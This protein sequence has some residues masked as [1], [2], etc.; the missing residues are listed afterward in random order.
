[1][2]PKKPVSTKHK[3]GWTA[4]GRSATSKPPPQLDLWGVGILAI[5]MDCL[6]APDAFKG[7][8]QL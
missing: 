3:A 8:G 6:P 7:L 5:A 1:M 2:D 4:V